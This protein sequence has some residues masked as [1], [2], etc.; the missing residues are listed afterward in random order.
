[1]NWKQ[2]D[3]ARPQQ[4][5]ASCVL[6]HLRTTHYALRTTKIGL[7]L[8]LILLTGTLF[9]FAGLPVFAQDP[10][11]DEVNDIAQHLNC[12]TCDTRSLDDC[13]TQTC[14]QW[15]EQ[16]K[17]LM[18]QG[19]TRQEILDWY[20][21]RYGEYVLQE[22]RMSGL[23]TLVWLLPIVAVAGGI[24]WLSFILRK[25]SAKTKKIAPVEISPDQTT[26]ARAN[27]PDDAYFRQV[28]QDLKESS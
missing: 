3:L 23:A 6:A 21:A 27:A 14:I 10:T 25:W 22:P 7:L 26:A 16:I 24:V 28:E 1:M 13:N 18:S 2:P 12:P 5:V 19:Y 20:V 11:A 4:Q 8:P 9:L 15:K 17:D